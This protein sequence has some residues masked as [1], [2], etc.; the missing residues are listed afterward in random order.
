[1]PS[2]TIL[3]EPIADTCDPG[4]LSR[5]RDLSPR[6][7]YCNFCC[8]YG[9][10]VVRFIADNPFHPER[11]SF[12]VCERHYADRFALA[13][14]WQERQEEYRLEQAALQERRRR[15]EAARQERQR[16]EAQRRM[17]SDGGRRFG[18]ELEVEIDTDSNTIADA[19]LDRGI[20]CEAPGY[21]HEVM[22]CWKVVSDS[23][24]GAG[25]EIVS[26]PMTMERAKRE[27]PIV[28]ETLSNL[29]AVPADSCGLHVHHEVADLDIGQFKR[30]VHRWADAQ[31]FI[32]RMVAPHRR[33]GNSDWCSSFSS[34]ELRAI[35]GMTC[36]SQINN[37]VYI[38]RYKSLNVSAF[39]Q[40]GTV[41]VRQHQSTLDADEI[42]AWTAFVQD[43]ISAAVK[44]DEPIEASV[45]DACQ[46]VESIVT[47]PAFKKKMTDKV[48]AGGG[49][50]GIRSNYYERDEDDDYYDRDYDEECDCYVCRES[51]GELW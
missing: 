2:F 27:V 11:D 43:L 7:G 42:L 37:D 50:T 28:T 38:D 8:E 9:E 48:L 13:A 18:I 23:S 17:A 22:N 40:Y 6:Y 1:M 32:D 25:W 20:S 26:P 46:L 49:P 15:E 51:R 30:L 12:Y 31:P 29:G 41:E 10:E 14:D 39:S 4:P 16:R 33:D 3:G 36:M 44:A 47:D 19:L 35:D 34:R 21:T 45:T 5:F 24:V